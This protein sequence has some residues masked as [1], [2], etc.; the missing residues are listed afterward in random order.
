M[1]ASPIFLNLKINRFVLTIRRLCC[2]LALL[3]S[4]G[5]QAQQR[6]PWGLM[7]AIPGDIDFVA[8]VDNPARA[9]LSDEGQ[10]SRGF[11]GSIGLFGK[12]RQAW[13]SIADL[14]GTDADGVI[15]Q[16]LSRRVVVVVDSLFEHSDNP[17]MM[18][19]TAD[20][21][22]VL[23]G[24][25]DGGDEAF[26]QLRKRLKP[27]PREI[28]SGVAVYGIEQGRYAL[29]MLS[30]RDGQAGRLLLCPRGGRDLLERVL[31][32]VKDRVGDEGAQPIPMWRHDN[33][34]SLA[35]RV[36]VDSWIGQD[37]NSGVIASHVSG[38][39]GFDAD[40]VVL[41]LSMPYQGDR[42]GGA[43]PLG[44]LDALD[45]D[46]VGAIATA[47]VLRLVLDDQE[48]LSILLRAQNVADLKGTVLEPNGSLMVFDR[49][50]LRSI[51]R[52][53]DSMGMTMLSI[54]DAG[55]VDA[56]SIDAIVEPMVFSDRAGFPGVSQ[57]SEGSYQGLFP[58]AVRT[59]EFVDSS[60]SE[61]NVSWLTSQRSSTSDLIF[62]FG[63]EGTD[64]T[65]RVRSVSELVASLDAIGGGGAVQSAVIM[66]GYAQI[67]A[68]A[69][70]FG[71]A[72]W[73]GGN[74]KLDQMGFVRWEVVQEVGALRGSV[75]IE[76]GQ[77]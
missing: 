7:D 42:V 74:A 37:D 72:T 38:L 3:C 40:G 8:V 75:R 30:P 16:L 12:T 48:G 23:I 66:K 22:W 14:L 29:V 57:K 71:A 33:N 25:V 11:F 45:E 62:S 54:F 51:Q 64:T 77:D 17:I 67:G 69:E 44:I 59:H 9:L 35:M 41:E 32:A 26:A 5:V 13:G 53:T 52:G 39:M 43:A 20:T 28:V 76:P 18:A 34:W 15:E 27:I 55:E 6:E 65:K 47:G 68:L 36:R 63:D 50:D 46:V 58:K 70:S 49:D 56:S 2:V 31:V 19:N 1:S 10:A 60:G 4:A 73:M 61:E 24:E 21:N